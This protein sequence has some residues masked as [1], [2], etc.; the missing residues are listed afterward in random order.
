VFYSIRYEKRQLGLYKAWE[1]EEQDLQSSLLNNI[2]SLD[3]LKRANVRLE[4][5]VHKQKYGH[6]KYDN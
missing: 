3:S 2:D 6:I 5:V 4:K 1:R